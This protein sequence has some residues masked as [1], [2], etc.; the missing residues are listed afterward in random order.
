MDSEALDKLQMVFKFWIASGRM[1]YAQ[2]LIARKGKVAWHKGAGE[3]AP[4]KPAIPDSIFRLHS[5]TK[6]ITSMGLIKLMEEGRIMVDHPVHLFLGEKWKKEN[7]KVYVGGSA[8]DAQFEPCKRNITIHHLLTHTAGFSYPSGQFNDSEDNPVASFYEDFYEFGSW[9]ERFEQMEK[10]Q[11]GEEVNDGMYQQSINKKGMQYLVET[12]P[13]MPLIAQPGIKMHYGFSTT[14]LGSIIEA[15]TGMGYRQWIKTQFMDLMDMH[16]T[17][18]WIKSGEWHR[19]AHNYNAHWMGQGQLRS[20]QDMELND[21]GMYQ[22][23]KTAFCDPG[24]GMVSTDLDYWKFVQMLL[25]GGIAPNGKRILGKRSVQFTLGNHLP[26]GQMMHECYVPSNADFAF[27]GSGW[28]CGGFT[29]NVNPD[30]TRHFNGTTTMGS[31]GWGGAAGS[32]W[33]IDVQEEFAYVFQTQVMNFDQWETRPRSTIG[34]I[35]GGAIMPDGPLGLP[36]QPERPVD[37][38]TLFDDYETDW[39]YKETAKS[40]LRLALKE[41]H[42]MATEI[43]SKL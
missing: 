30:A 33:V 43:K 32:L 42:E 12:L 16:D 5:M 17:D 10:H 3:Y 31:I 35:I 34:N 4:G 1:K 26:A 41:V 23:G 14:V 11:G 19:F 24:G 25:N 8:E 40:N 27:T 18:F 15:I 2:L 20:I 39:T 13:L 38:T 21:M 22:E 6:T 7:M 28:S 37:F 36:R 9:D 29:V